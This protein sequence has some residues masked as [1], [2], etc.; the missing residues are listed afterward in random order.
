MEISGRL[1]RT[2][3]QSI[4]FDRL[5]TGSAYWGTLG[6]GLWKTNDSGQTWNRIGKDEF[7]TPNITSV[8]VSSLKEETDRFN[9]VYVG[10]EP[11]A[12]YVSNDKCESWERLSD[13]NN[14]KSSALWSFPPR[15]WT[16][17]IRWIEPDIN[18]LNYI[19]VAIEAGALVKSHDG[20]RTWIDRIKEG[21][22]DTLWQ[23]IK[24]HLKGYTHLQTMVI[25]K[26]LIMETLGIDL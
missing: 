10:T 13:L 9:K 11:S 2:H 1:E 14:L 12:L 6:D 26:V 7:Y 17:H 20:G 4:M 24:R 21:P 19:F 22:Y 5:D 18:N 16:H 8:S 3:P 25:L 15:P 23:L